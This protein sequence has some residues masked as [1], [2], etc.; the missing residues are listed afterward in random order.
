MEEFEVEFDIYP[1]DDE[2]V[3]GLT[4]RGIDWSAVGD[5]QRAHVDVRADSW[6]EAEQLAREELAGLGVQPVGPG[7]QPE[8]AG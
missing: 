2:A 5:L 6:S 1:I 7:R 8:V 4:A 3:S